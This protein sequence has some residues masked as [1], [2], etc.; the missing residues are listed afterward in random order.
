MTVSNAYNRP[1]QIAPDTRARVLAEA[2][3]LGY[4]GPHPTARSLRRRR[5]GTVGLLYAGPL[6]YAFSD[7]AAILFLQ[8]VSQATEAAHLSVLLLSGSAP[9]DVPL[10]A[11]AAVDG[12]LTFALAD[13]DPL[14]GA[15]MAR[16]VPLVLVDQPAPAGYP[17]VGIDDAGAA[18]TAAAHVVGLGHRQVGIL[19]LGL[20]GGVGRRSGPADAARQAA[21]THPVARNRLAG[22]AAALAAVD[23][24]WSAVP[25]YEC[26]GLALEDGA[27]AAAWLLDQVPRPTAL[28]AMSD[29][30]ALGALDAARARGLDVPDDLSV[31]G[32]DDIPAAAR[33]TPGLTTVRQPHGEKGQRAGRALVDAVQ[34]RAP[35][36][37]SAV[38]LPT[39]LIVRASAGPAPAR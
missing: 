2:A 8:G 36:D 5:T 34:G 28:L 29:Q 18:Q 10:V 39:A 15:A 6:S 4:P 31:V 23:V 11:E 22:Y 20:G 19:A 14:L 30:L 21:A 25:V 32:F 1:D 12:L 27:Q 38:V 17:R 24:P 9:A 16:R 37:V 7:P 3:R 35:A 33:A 26:G 13:D